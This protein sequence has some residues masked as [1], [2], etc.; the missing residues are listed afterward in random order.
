VDST[1]VPI[2]RETQDL[3]D[4]YVERNPALTETALPPP[5]KLEFKTAGEYGYFRGLFSLALVVVLALCITP[6]TARPQREKLGGLTIWT[7]ADGKRSFK[8]GTPN[9]RPGRAVRLSIRVTPGTPEDGVQL[10]AADLETLA[11][12]RGD[13]LYLADAR[14]RLGGLRSLHA[15]AGQSH[16]DTGIALIPEGLFNASNLLLHKEVRVEKII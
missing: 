12:E 3:L 14:K 11:A 1:G 6:F 16:T 2:I 7:I 8:D 5:V 10:S 13:L 9:E 15:K 4:N